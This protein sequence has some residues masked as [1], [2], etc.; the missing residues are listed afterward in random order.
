MQSRSIAVAAVLIFVAVTAGCGEEVK[1]ERA[2]NARISVGG[3]TLTT[4]DVSCRQLEWSLIIEAK[5]GPTRTRSLLEL[6][7][8]QPI[9]KTVDINDFDGFSGVAGEGAGSAEV[10][11][12]NN[13]YV[14]TGSAQGSD[15]ENPGETRTVPFRLETPC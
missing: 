7:G 2:K 4:Q 8:E 14:I 9:A 5:S 3:K 10:S 11:L 6:G 15:P 12:V 1:P 13:A